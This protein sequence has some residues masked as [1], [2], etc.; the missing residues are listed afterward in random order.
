MEMK[1]FSGLLKGVASKAL[2]M[3]LKA[4]TGYQADITVNE[5]NAHVKDGRAHVH[6]N[7]DA[8]MSQDELKKILAS[9][10]LG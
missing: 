3:A 10:G 5:F 4:K 9:V 7:I 2:S 6:L 8:D 1:L